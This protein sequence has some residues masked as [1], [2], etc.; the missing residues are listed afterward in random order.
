MTYRAHLPASLSV[1]VV[2][3]LLAAAARGEERDHPFLLCTREDFPELRKRADREP[4]ASM[5]ADAI[6]RA[7]RG[8]RGKGPTELHRY[9]GACAL[10]CILDESAA[11]AH[12]KRVRDAITGGLTR[13]D[14]DPKKE[15]TGTVPTMGAAFVCILALDVV[16]DELSARDL[17][18]CERAIERQIGKI[19]RKGSWPAARY[20]THG[21]WDIYTGKRT[22]PDDAFHRN[23]LR[24][25]TPDGVTTVSPAYAFG[26]LGSDDSRPQK[27]GYADVLEHTGID[28]RYYD[29]PKLKRFYRW[30]FSA[31]IDPARQYHLFGDVTPY[32]KP[33]NNL[34]L[35]RVGRFDRKA[36]AYAAWLLKGH[37]PAGHLLSYILMTEPLPEPIVPASQLFLLGEAVFRE[38]ADSPDSLGA[39]LYNITTGAEWHTHQEVNAVSCSAYG[40]RLLVNGGWLGDETRPPARN[41][42]LAIDGK[43]HQRRTGA[44]LEEGLLGDGLDYAR[45]DSGKALGDDR[46]HRSLLLVHG[47]DDC[48]GYFVVLDEID[49]DKGEKVHSFLQP[50]TESDIRV[51]AERREYRAT[52]DHHARVEGVELSILFGL[53]P[54]SV[55]SELV[56][57]GYLQRTPRSGKH[58]R[59]AARYATDPRGDVRIPTVLF[60][61]DA[62]HPKASLSRLDVEGLV[63]A[64]VAF[65]GKALDVIAQSDGTSQHTVAGCTFRAEATVF[66]TRGD[67]TSFFFVRDGRSFRDGS[68]GFQSDDDVTI[69]LA[70]ARGCITGPGGAITVRRPNL[71]AVRIDGQAARATQADGGLRVD[72]PAGRHDLELVGRP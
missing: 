12:A 63:G 58:Y 6:G 15:W 36:A 19:P 57:S 49:A 37:K 8:V 16:H 23:Y 7:K 45:G 65:A 42:T 48:P 39:A 72:V 38:P 44:G 3:L 52:I 28:R 25:M 1:I 68:T 66:R 59:L 64:R 24:Q 2:V 51:V 17:T 53:E 27:T 32:W 26:R 5:R 55:R 33:G 22:T 69:Y 70:G 67:G 21:T 30:L 11:P 43:Q 35:W 46:F 18:A 41:N 40:N 10:A 31:S 20:G 47:R 54:A 4:W 14:F 62:S 9:V 60:P 71:A 29:H 56:R 50:A 13:I 34:L 61:H